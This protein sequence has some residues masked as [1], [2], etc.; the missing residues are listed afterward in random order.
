MIKTI[1]PMGCTEWCE[2]CHRKC[3]E[4]LQAFYVSSTNNVPAKILC[5]ACIDL[6]LNEN[7]ILPEDF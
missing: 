2:H 5:N 3:V 1:Y 6:A 4:P 7:M